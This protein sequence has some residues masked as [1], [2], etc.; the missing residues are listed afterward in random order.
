MF[1]YAYREQESRRRGYDGL[2][3][4]VFRSEEKQA[5]KSV[6]RVDLEAL[7]KEISI[8]IAE[9]KRDIRGLRRD[10]L[11]RKLSLLEDDDDDDAF[12]ARIDGNKPISSPT[13]TCTQWIMLPLF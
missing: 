3:E 9:L 13:T 7:E 10:L 12:A 1:S 4:R 11:S 5:D 6:G 2:I 8:D